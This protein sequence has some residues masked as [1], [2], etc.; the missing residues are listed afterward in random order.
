MTYEPVEEGDWA[1]PDRSTC[2]PKP[3]DCCQ[4]LITMGNVFTIY[5]C[6]RCG[7]EEGL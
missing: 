1:E 4:C 5:K 7:S 2:G 3:S 6:C